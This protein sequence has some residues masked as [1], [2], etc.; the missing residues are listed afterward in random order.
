[1]SRSKNTIRFSDFSTIP[2]KVT[3]TSSYSSSSLNSQGIS[4]YTGING[5]ISTSG[6]LEKTTINYITTRHLY[7]SNY[8]TGSN[9]TTTSSYDNFL[10]SSA[11]S[12]SGDW[13]NRYF[14]TES[15]SQIR[16]LSIPRQ[17]YGE[18]ISRRGF[19]M[20]SSAYSIYDD[21]NGNLLINQYDDNQ[22]YISGGYFTSPEDYYQSTSSL[23]YP[24]THIGNILYAQGIVV[25]THQDYLSIFNT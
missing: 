3:Y 10:Q 18:R 8:L 20:S 2:I 15:N 9:L 21:G 23:H 6:S 1:M 14:P 22:P 11:A 7:Y 24:I 17:V 13:D 16:I 4:L 5:A 25:I 19:F 12:G